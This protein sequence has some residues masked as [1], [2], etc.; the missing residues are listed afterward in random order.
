MDNTC[1]CTSVTVSKMARTATG[2]SDSAETG[3]LCA[4]YDDPNCGMY[5]EDEEDFIG[6]DEDDDED[7]EAMMHDLPPWRTPGAAW[8][9]RP[10]M[11]V[12]HLLRAA[13]NSS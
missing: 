10:A 4:G 5:S 1:N 13:P 6:S 11:H 9:A 12:R 7:R 8:A 2:M 3:K